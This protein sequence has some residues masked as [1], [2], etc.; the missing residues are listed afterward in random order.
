MQFAGSLCQK[1]EQPK[2]KGRLDLLKTKASLAGFFF[3]SEELVV[4]I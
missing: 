4:K 1:R 2:T 3:L